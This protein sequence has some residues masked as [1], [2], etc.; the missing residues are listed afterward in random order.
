VSYLTQS[1]VNSIFGIVDELRN[2]SNLNASKI[3]D[4]E[5][6]WIIKDLLLWKG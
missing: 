1:T 5:E 2:S 6:E 3:Y 4:V